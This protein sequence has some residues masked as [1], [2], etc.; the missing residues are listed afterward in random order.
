VRFTDLESTSDV[1]RSMSFE[2]HPGLGIAE[3]VCVWVR[4]AWVCVHHAL[5]LYVCVPTAVV[6]YKTTAGTQV[7][8]EGQE[9]SLRLFNRKCNKHSHSWS[10]L[11][12]MG[13]KSTGL[14]QTLPALMSPG[15]WTQIPQKSTDNCIRTLI[16][17]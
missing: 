10:C 2:T 12:G 16:N 7:L 5:S 15:V 4:A 14:A 11:F 3:R 17:I 9:D 8:T 6:L 1:G 13:F